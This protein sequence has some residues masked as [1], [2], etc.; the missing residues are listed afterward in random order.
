MK[1][2]KAEKKAPTQ[3]EIMQDDLEMFDLLEDP[4][5]EDVLPHEIF[6]ISQRALEGMPVK[7]AIEGNDH[8]QYVAIEREGYFSV[9]LHSMT[10]IWNIER[11]TTHI[12]MSGGVL[13]SESKIDLNL[14]NQFNIQNPDIHAVVVTEDDDTQTLMIQHTILLESGLPFQNFVDRLKYFISSVKTV[15]LAFQYAKE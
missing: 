1:D 11:P 15:R 7:I 9:G 8:N 13:S 12:L 3:A 5:L 4:F 2:L 10:G 6:V 14:I